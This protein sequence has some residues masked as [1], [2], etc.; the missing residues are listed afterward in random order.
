MKPMETSDMV[1]FEWLSEAK[2]GLKLTKT[3]EENA[4]FSQNSSFSKL[5]IMCSAVSNEM[6]TRPGKEP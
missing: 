5:C 2:K 6:E 1:G 3:K 4:S